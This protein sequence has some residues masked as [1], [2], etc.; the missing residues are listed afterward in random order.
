[1]G[2]LII[3]LVLTFVGWAAFTQISARQ[4]TSVSCPY[5]VVTARAVVTKCFGRAWASV[6]GRGD[7]NYRARA[8]KRAPVISVSFDAA[9]GGGSDV[10]IWCSAFTKRYGLLE[11]GQL[12]WRKKRRVARA[13]APA[14]Q[15]RSHVTAA[16]SDGPRPP[17]P[18]GV[19]R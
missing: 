7:L 8:R 16:Q 14:Q 2:V 12:V 19:Q 5:D 15:G 13:L 3:L 1:V 10:D 6:P 18:E 17:H 9:E 11:H 4:Q